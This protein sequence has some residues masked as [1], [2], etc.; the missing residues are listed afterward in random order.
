MNTGVQQAQPQARRPQIFTHRLPAVRRCVVPDHAQRPGVPLPQPVQEG[1]RGSGVAVALQFHPL[2]LARLQTNRRVVAGLFAIP[3]AGRVHQSLPSWKRGADFPFSTHLPRSSASARK[4]ASSAKNIFPPVRPASSR[5]AAYSATKAS[6]F[7]P[8]AL[9][10]RFLG[11][12]NANPKRCNQFRQLLRL[13]TMPNCSSRKCLATF[14]FQ[15]ARPMPAAAGNSCTAHPTPAAPGN[16][17][18]P[19]RGTDPPP[20][21]REP[22][23]FPAPRPG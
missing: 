18:A 13:R 12:L 15:L 14:Q 9:T 20:T 6:R 17:S 21:P 4:W 10:K 22:R 5:R 8:S 19:P 3:R 7:L 23:P 11:R 16:L 1:S 2:H